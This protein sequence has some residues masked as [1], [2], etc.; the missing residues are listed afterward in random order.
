LEGLLASG[1]SN[2]VVVVV[3]LLCATYT[4]RTLLVNVYQYQTGELER[5][6]LDTITMSSNGHAAASAPKKKSPKYMFAEEA[7]SDGTPL[8]LV[9]FL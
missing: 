3:V 9:C 5:R 4:T 2:S 8:E 1:A 6:S 7:P